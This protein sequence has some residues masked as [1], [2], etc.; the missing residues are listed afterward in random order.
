MFRAFFERG[1][2]IGDVDVLVSLAEKL[3]LPGE[4]LREALHQRT[5]EPSVLRDERAAQNMGI[6]GVPAFVAGRRAA[7]TGVQPVEALSELVK[8]VRSLDL[9][10]SRE[11]R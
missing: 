5:C 9:E 1:E 7:I 6:S 3:R 2:D 10:T 8:H 11:S 4:S